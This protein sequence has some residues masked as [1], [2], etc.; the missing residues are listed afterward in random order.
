MHKLLTI[1][2]ISLA[3]A[4]CKTTNYNQAYRTYCPNCNAMCRGYYME[5]FSEPTYKNIDEVTVV[6]HNHE[7]DNTVYMSVPTSKKPDVIVEIPAYNEEGRKH[8]KTH[9]YR[10][11][12]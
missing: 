2:I 3:L 6:E 10:L 11:Y 12:K 4:G 1:T 9:R 7:S 5:S 8:G